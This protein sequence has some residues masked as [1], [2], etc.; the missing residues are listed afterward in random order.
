MEVKVELDIPN[1][2]GEALLRDVMN[3]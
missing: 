3:C 2:Y 1:S